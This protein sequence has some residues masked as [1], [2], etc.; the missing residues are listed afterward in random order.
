MFLR[1]LNINTLDELKNYFDKLNELD[2]S[3]ASYLFWSNF[4]KRK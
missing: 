4:E 2:K 3:I 1:F